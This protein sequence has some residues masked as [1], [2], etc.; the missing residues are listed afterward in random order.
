MPVRFSLRIFVIAALSAASLAG[1]LAPSAT[2]DESSLECHGSSGCEMA[3]SQLRVRPTDNRIDW[4]A[5]DY[6]TDDADPA[7]THTGP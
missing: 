1:S 7:N 6:D 5:S 2:A 4:G 3:I